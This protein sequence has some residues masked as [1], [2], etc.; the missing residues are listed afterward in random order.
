MIK[1]NLNLVQTY[2][3]AIGMKAIAMTDFPEIGKVVDCLKMIEV[4]V[5][6]PQ[7]GEVAIKMMASSLYADELYAAQGTALGRLISET[8]PKAISLLILAMW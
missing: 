2:Q 3:S 5:P 8:W 6:R 1:T 7:A 4:P